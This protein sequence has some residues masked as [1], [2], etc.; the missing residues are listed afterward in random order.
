MA[1]KK[2]ILFKKEMDRLILDFLIDLKNN[3]NRDWFQANR[4][5]YEKARGIFEDF[6]N[7]L[8]PEIRSFDPGIGMIT[9][10]DCAF[11]IYRDVRFSS[12]KS[13]YKPNMGAYIAR[14]GKSSAM[15]G[16][17]VHIEPGASFL[18]GGM[19]MP[20]P[21]V[22]KRIRDEIFYQPEEFKAIISGKKFRQY[23]SSGFMEEDKLK[24]PP[25][26][27]SP[28]F[29]DIELLKY[30]S[31]AVMHPVTDQMV[32]DAGYPGYAREAFRALYPLNAFFNSLF[33]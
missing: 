12:D 19:Y 16:Y 5:K 24:K 28:D 18:A 30:K 23:F 3:N 26:G 11:R 15:A 4:H 1:G 33:A 6:V 20:Q 31:Y 29:A 27:Y 25:K 17:Y 7:E 2:V 32:A 10:K 14:G 13:P 9:A 8:I 21:D 22:L